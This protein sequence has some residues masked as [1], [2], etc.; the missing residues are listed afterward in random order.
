MRTRGVMCVAASALLVAGIA[1]TASL[2]A[3]A[4][5][6]STPTVKWYA[7]PESGGSTVQ[8]A[9]NGTAAANGRYKIEISPLPADATQ[10]REQLVRRLAANDSSI[11]L[12]S[13]DV[14]WTAEFAGA[15][16]IVPWSKHD[17]STIGDGVIPAVLK[18][19]QY[20]GR[21]Y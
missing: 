9:K 19:G 16:W 5:A 6:R 3:P 13:M 20:R 10:Q 8:A 11:D 7:R 12:I 1:G 17:A 15:K 4:A 2:A 21:M 18:T 14:V